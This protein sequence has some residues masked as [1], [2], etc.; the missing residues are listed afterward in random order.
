MNETEYKRVGFHP[1][2]EGW[3]LP[4]DTVKSLTRA[5]STCSS[6]GF[7]RQNPASCKLS[8]SF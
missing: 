2:P 6:V 5:A 4:A 1:N 8:G 3:G 7:Q